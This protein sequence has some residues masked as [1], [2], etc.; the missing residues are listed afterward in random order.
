MLAIMDMV[1]QMARPLLEPEQ[2]VPLQSGPPRGLVAMACHRDAVQY[3]REFCSCWEGMTQCLSQHAEQ[4]QPRCKHLLEA[5]GVFEDPKIQNHVHEGHEHHSLGEEEQEEEAHEADRLE[6]KAEQAQE[7][8]QEKTQQ[9]EQAKEN[10]AEAARAAHEKELQAAEKKAAEEAAKA[11]AKRALEFARRPPPLSMQ[12]ALQAMHDS[13]TSD[14]DATRAAV[15]VDT[16]MQ[17]QAEVPPTDH[18]EPMSETAPAYTTG[19]IEEPQGEK[20]MG[21]WKMRQYTPEQQARLSVNANG[22]HVDA[23]TDTQQP[24]PQPEKAT[25]RQ[26]EG[27]STSGSTSPAQAFRAGDFIMAVRQRLTEQPQSAYVLALA[28]AL[29]AFFVAAVAGRCRRRNDASALRS[30]YSTIESSRAMPMVET[31]FGSEDQ[32]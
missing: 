24:A 22:D 4:I 31:T 10:A 12:A 13:V 21:G 1:R 17:A 25:P 7:E 29:V 16:E 14:I 3:C 2:K 28:G 18:Q 27:G 26:A 23:P 6:E 9:A 5:S 20:D 11:A 8:A 19:D 15:K 30:A 32:I